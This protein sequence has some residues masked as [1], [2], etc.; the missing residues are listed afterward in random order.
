MSVST[1]P[2]Q[3]LNKAPSPGSHRFLPP[4]STFTNG[5]KQSIS[6]Q[7][8]STRP[9]DSPSMENHNSFIELKEDI[10]YS[11][12]ARANALQNITQRMNHI[13]LDIQEF[14]E[15]STLGDIEHLRRV[16]CMHVRNI[17]KHDHN[18]YNIPIATHHVY[19]E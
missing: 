6:A 7:Y 19:N 11:L 16:D 1:R 3:R 2:L 14:A 9:T 18:T 17:P 4:V 10:R 13:V 12:R 8:R 5:I 15:D